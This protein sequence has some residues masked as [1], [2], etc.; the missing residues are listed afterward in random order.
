M[1]RLIPYPVLMLLLPLENAL[2]MGSGEMTMKGPT[3]IG[4]PPW[5]QPH[6]GPAAGEHFLQVRR[7]EKHRITGLE[8]IF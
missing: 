7:S 2:G 6:R 1:L 4:I 8:G 5:G 3:L